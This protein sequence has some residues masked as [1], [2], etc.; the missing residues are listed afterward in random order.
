MKLNPKMVYVSFGDAAS[1][2]D[3]SC[4]F[5][6]WNFFY[7]LFFSLAYATKSIFHIEYYWKNITALTN[8]H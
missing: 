8:S 6:F 1:S 7:Y 2:F 4:E 5:S 3:I